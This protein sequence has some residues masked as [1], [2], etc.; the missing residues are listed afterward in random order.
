VHSSRRSRKKKKKKKKK[1]ASSSN[2]SKHKGAMGSGQGSINPI[3]TKLDFQRY[4]GTVAGLN[5]I[6]SFNKLKMKIK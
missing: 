2:I 3:L 5:R 1:K 4:D 6:S